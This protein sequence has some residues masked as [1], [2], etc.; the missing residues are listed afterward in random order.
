[1]GCPDC[2]SRFCIDF[3]VTPQGKTALIEM[4]DG[5]SF[6]A[7]DGLSERIYWDITWARWREILLLTAGR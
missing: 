3:G 1:M 2:T 4:N 5:F 6:G 7:Y